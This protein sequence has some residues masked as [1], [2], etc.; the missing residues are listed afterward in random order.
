M[1]EHPRRVARRLVAVT[2]GGD[3]AP[4]GGPDP[5]DMI[6]GP[7]HRTRLLAVLREL[8]EATVSM[9]SCSAGA[10]DADRAYVLDLRDESGLPVDVDHLD[11][12]VRALVRALLA[13]SNGRPR[14]ADY[15]LELAMR[16]DPR[17]DPLDV[18]ALALLWTVGS[19]EWCEE[20][21]APTPG[22]LG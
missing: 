2:R 1:T 6:A 5:M 15:Q 4:G 8:V 14:D 11:P 13:E 7:E 21:D 10:F 18:L 19:M 17:F 22:W 12:P 3:L 9:M 20:H 16:D